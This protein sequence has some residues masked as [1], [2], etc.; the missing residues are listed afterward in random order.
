[1]NCKACSKTFTSTRELHRHI[2]TSKKCLAVIKEK[3]VQ[4]SPDKN[5]SIEDFKLD[6]KVNIDEYKLLMQY[7]SKT[8][9]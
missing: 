6:V 9:L 3:Q 5:N 1:M 7:R 8:Q 4:K 2:N